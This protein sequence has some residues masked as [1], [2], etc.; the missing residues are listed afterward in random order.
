MLVIAV[1][2]WGTERGGGEVVHSLYWK[3]IF[4][5]HPKHVFL[6]CRYRFQN[7]NSRIRWKKDK[8]TNMVSEFIF[9]LCL[10]SH[11]ECNVWLYFIPDTFGSSDKIHYLL[12]VIMIRDGGWSNSNILR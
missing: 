10:I 6:F 3:Q 8:V 4:K 5:S 9:C 11:C 1:C 2:L 7:Q 12:K